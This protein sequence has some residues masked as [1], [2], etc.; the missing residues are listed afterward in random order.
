MTVHTSRYSTESSLG[1]SYDNLQD[2]L[3]GKGMGTGS[4]SGGL[5]DLALIYQRG[6]A[7]KHNLAQTEYSQAQTTGQL[8]KNTA[9]QAQV[10]ATQRALKDPAFTAMFGNKA[11]GGLGATNVGE[12]DSLMDASIKHKLLPA[13]LEQQ[14]RD[15]MAD[16]MMLGVP[17]TLEGE[18][19][20]T[21]AK[22]ME[23]A[24][25]AGDE[26]QVSTLMEILAEGGQ[27]DPRTGPEEGYSDPN[28][29]YPTASDA[30]RGFM[31]KYGK[32]STAEGVYSQAEANQVRNKADLL[33]RYKISEEGRIEVI[34]SGN[35][36]AGVKYTSDGVQIAEMMKNA[37]KA[38]TA[39]YGHQTTLKAALDKN[40]LAPKTFSAE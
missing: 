1:R 25:G 23:I 38:S 36:L 33:A 26:G 2:L 9:L 8:S 13:Q 6:T 18:A 16:N 40:I 35:I 10:E 11:L 5:T 31:Y 7:G 24:S 20:V 34:K 29:L 22:E 19:P 15:A 37:L 27:F 21:L 28:A 17:T 39:V 30:R 14:Q 4:G 12:I 32:E 3:L